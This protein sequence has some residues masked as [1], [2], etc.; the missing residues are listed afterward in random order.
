MK[1]NVFREVSQ[2][3]AAVF[4]N[5]SEFSREWDRYEAAPAQNRSPLEGRW[6]GQWIS[7]ANG[8]HG[9]LQC[10][11]TLE[12]S[13]NYRA[14]FHATFSRALRVC[15]TAHLNAKKLENSVEIE[16]E[17]DLGKLAGG[18][19]HYHGTV[20]PE[21]FQCSYRCS[22]DHGKFDMSPIGSVP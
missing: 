11:L 4:S 12:P 16:G 13:G 21:K 3:L 10:L 17:A 15:Y 5:C 6:E 9:T 2:T 8:H 19:Y 18:L 1:T 7:D 22:Y 14:F 20:T